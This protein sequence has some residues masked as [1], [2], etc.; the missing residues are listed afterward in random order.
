MN[1]NETLVADNILDNT[2]TSSQSAQGGLTPN[3][4]D[5]IETAGFFTPF[6]KKLKSPWVI[7]AVV[8]LTISI[9]IFIDDYLDTLHQDIDS[10]TK[11]VNNLNSKVTKIKN[12]QIPIRMNKQSIDWQ[13]N[14]IKELE[15]SHKLELRI[16]ALENK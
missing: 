11:Q 4:L 1:H 8:A 9:T 7:F 3:Q 16:Q 6:V 13:I 14:Y 5:H 15:K 12:D 2:N 10:L